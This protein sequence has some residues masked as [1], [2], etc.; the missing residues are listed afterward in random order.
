MYFPHIIR[1]VVAKVDVEMWDRKEDPFHVFFEYGLV[2]DVF[3]SV[4]WKREDRVSVEPFVW[5]PMPF[6]E[7]NINPL[8]TEV[9]FDLFLFAFT[10]ADYVMSKREE[11]N[12]FP[13]L[14]LIQEGIIKAIHN[15]PILLADYHIPFTR[16]IHPYWG[17]DASGNNNTDNFSNYKVDAV[18]MKG[19]KLSIDLTANPN[20]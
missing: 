3:K 1:D 20:C 16:R 17:G 15:T 13:R 6:D 4:Q 11:I 19:V 2:Q 5:L 7:T 9:V 18:Q 10:E 12:F 14:F 8:R